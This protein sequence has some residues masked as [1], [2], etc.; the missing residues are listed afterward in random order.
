MSGS[1]LSVEELRR[2]TD[3]L[4]AGLHV[5]GSDLSAQAAQEREDVA[6][7]VRTERALTQLRTQID[8]ITQQPIAPRETTISGAVATGEEAAV[9]AEVTRRADEMQQARAALE[10]AQDEWV[11][12]RSR[13]LAE[14]RGREQE[15]HARESAFSSERESLAAELESL[16]SDLGRLTSASEAAQQLQQEFQTLH[17]LQQQWE[18]ERKAMLDEKAGMHAATA[19]SEQARE[20]LQAQVA[21]LQKDAADRNAALNSEG[22]SLASDLDAARHELAE[23]PALKEELARLTGQRAELLQHI[24]LVEQHWYQ[25]EATFTVERAGWRRELDNASFAHQEAT[26]ELERARRRSRRDLFALVSAGL[27]SLAVGFSLGLVPIGSTVPSEPAGA[28]LGI[29]VAAAFFAYAYRTGRAAG[30][31]TVPGMATLDPA[32]AGVTVAPVAEALITPLPGQPMTVAPAVIAPRQPAYGPRKRPRQGPV[33]ILLLGA[34]LVIGLLPIIAILRGALALLGGPSGYQGETWF[35]LLLAF[36]ALIM[37]AMFF[38]YSVKYYLATAVVLL[39][40]GGGLN[41]ATAS[42]LE[43]S[44]PHGPGD[45]A[46]VTQG[47]LPVGSEPFV[48]IH[49]AT[50]NEKRVLERLLAAC[51]QFEYPNYEVI[52]VDDSTDESLEILERWKVVPRFKVI[53]RPS[54][55][56]FKG[57]ALKVALAATDP[58]AQYVVVFDADSIPFPDSIQRLLFHF[59]QAPDNGAHEPGWLLRPGVGAVQSYQWHVLNRSES[60]L[61]QA[62][63]T[64]YAGS[65]MVERPFQEAIGSLKMIAGTAYM[66]RADLLRELGWGRS[67]TEDWELTLRLY[68]KGY[69]VVYTPYAETPAECVSTFTRLARQRM[70]WAE[71]HTYNVRKWF[72]SVIGSSKLSLA[73]KVGFAFYATYYLQALFMF[74]GSF[75]WLLSE[76]VFKVHVP[77]WTSVMGWSLVISNLLSLPVMNLSALVLEGAPRRDIS[78]VLGALATSFLLVPFQAWA[79]IKGLIEP[80]EGPWFR[81]PKTGRIT[82]PVWPLRRLGLLRRWLRGPKSG[83]SPAPGPARI[84]ANIA[85]PRRPARRLAWVMIGGL[86]LCLGAIGFGALHAPVAE[87]AGTQNFYLHH[88][89]SGGSIAFVRSAS[90]TEVAAATSITV[91]ISSTAGDLLVGV[92]AMNDTDNEAPLSMTDTAGNTWYKIVTE[93]SCG[94]SKNWSS[95]WYAKNAAAV[96]SV[97]FNTSNND[98]AAAFVL[99]FSGADHNAPL[100]VFHGGCNTG[101][102]PTSGSITPSFTNDVIVGSIE[103]PA[104]VTFSAGPTFSSGTTNNLP[105]SGIPIQ[106]N[107]GVGA[108]QD[109]ITGYDLPGTAA[110][111]TYSGTF[112]LSNPYSGIIAAFQTSGDWMDGTAPSGGSATTF[113]MTA[114]SA[115][116]TWPTT[117]QTAASQTIFTTAV[118]NFNYWTSLTGTA[119]VTITFGYQSTGFGSGGSA[120]DSPTTIATQTVTL[121]AGSNLQTANFSPASNV[122]VG[123]NSFFCLTVT[124]N[125]VTGGGLN[126]LY[127]STTDKTN[128]ISSQTIFIPEL[129][130]G[131]LGIALIAPRLSRLRRQRAG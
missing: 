37:G 86:F 122:N 104:T 11:S 106:S 31:A 35:G 44:Q 7:L 16:R 9:D 71:G 102:G 4:V 30:S 108:I 92:I 73:E 89:S 57:G 98:I 29:L 69:K 65:Y 77:E 64:E 117:V 81:T 109:L 45:S 96:T 62:I 59:Y 119:N 47:W 28:I 38:A 67:L 87:A 50:Y 8:A 82:D 41:D 19:E 40:Y 61:T 27:L 130:L 100:D 80:S 5:L 121:T 42:R 129:A 22:G 68:T 12:E 18:I 43:R 17:A 127:D 83:A 90:Q 112:A 105:A 58:R 55:D 3:A 115:T 94:A 84:V 118:F 39:G 66:I 101:T 24:E 123:A 48:S 20:L 131:L 14:L 26:A 33:L 97:T 49:I 76:V 36:L 114:A 46:A 13:M 53:H 21:R 78:G 120:C 10:A 88:S 113:A 85:P 75:C 126:L 111:Q 124:V 63:R 116:D 72:W 74:A 51:S 15:M 60:W 110:S 1:P 23:L 103:A 25:R 107:G 34:A 32:A 52:L 91:T 6:L 79:A 56:G 70:R 95:M 2:R 128:L 99:E 93:G 125:S 54:R